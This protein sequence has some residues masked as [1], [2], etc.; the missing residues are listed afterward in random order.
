MQEASLERIRALAKKYQREGLKWHFHLLTPSCV[1]NK[2][3]QYAFVL[4]CNEN[5]A[6]LVHYSRKP[7]RE[8]GEE[9]APLVHGANILK[10]EKSQDI[11]SPSEAGKKI[12]GRARELNSANIEW[13][14]HVFAPGCTF[15]EEGAKYILVFEDPESNE[16]LK[17]ESEHEPTNDLKEIEKLFYRK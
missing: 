4:E 15:N 5:K 2:S 13:H 3:G 11:S 12:I 10:N 17:N 9:L 16:V 1:F 14:H 8:L 7:E 6:S